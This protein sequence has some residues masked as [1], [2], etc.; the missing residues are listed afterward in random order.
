MSDLRE[1]LADLIHVIWSDWTRWQMEVL[2]P[3][4]D[5]C[6]VIPQALVDRW[7]RQMK[8]PYPYLSET[9][10]ESD[11]READRILA[12]L[13]AYWGRQEYRDMEEE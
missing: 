6:R 2:T 5:G 10:K 9:E 12:V 3:V 8:T 4:G 11:R 13:A 7:E 1:Q